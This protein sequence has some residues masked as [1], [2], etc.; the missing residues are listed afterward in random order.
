MVIPH[1]VRRTA[2]NLSYNTKDSRL[3]H[4]T[5]GVSCCPTKKF[6]WQSPVWATALPHSSKALNTTRTPHVTTQFRA[7]CT[8]NS[9]TIMFPISNLSPRL[10]STPKKLDA[11]FHKRCAR[12]KITRSDSPRSQKPVS[13]YCAGQRWTD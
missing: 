2:D 10:K 8:Y 3:K 4:I 12:Q 6:A 11:T 1:H 7:L 13:R 5:Q 9:A